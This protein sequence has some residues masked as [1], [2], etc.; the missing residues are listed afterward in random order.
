MDFIEKLIQAFEND[1][2]VDDKLEKAAGTGDPTI[3]GEDA[4]DKS[5]N[6]GSPGDEGD[7]QGDPEPN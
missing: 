2:N 5:G 3:P 1:E 6:P 4:N 7:P